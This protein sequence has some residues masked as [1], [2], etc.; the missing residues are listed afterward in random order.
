[1]SS[2]EGGRIGVV[3]AGTMGAG[4][5][6]SCITAGFQV[7][8]YDSFPAALERCRALI[9]GN[10]EKAAARGRF[11]GNIEATIGRLT[12]A[13]GPE[14]LA[15]CELVIEAAPE[16][17]ELKR[18][19]F[20]ELDRVCRADATLATNTSSIPVTAI[21]AGTAHPERVVGM[22][23][24][25]PVPRMRLVEVI[26]AARTAEHSVEH[27]RAVGEALGKRVILAPDTPGF[28]VNRCGRPYYGEALRLLQER[29]ADVAQIDRIC[30]M[31][32]GFRMGP[33]ELIDLVGV[34]VNFAIAQSFAELSFGEPRW[35]P[36]PLQAQLVASGDHGRKTGRGW[37]TYTAD[38]HRPEDPVPPE[39]SVDPSVVV[40]ILGNGPT[41]ARLRELAG[42][43]GLRTR[44]EVDASVS[45]TVFADPDVSAAQIGSVPRPIVSCAAHS[46]AFRG[47]HG[48]VG[49]C[50][51]NLGRAVPVVE[52][53]RLGSTSDG[54]AAQ[55]AALFTGLGI[56]VEWVAD[57]PGLVVERVL[58]QIV[59]EAAFAVGEGVATE[60]DVDTGVTLG[61]NY[62]LGPLA[63]G[64]ELGWRQVAV[65]LDGVW[66]ERREE[67]YRPAPALIRAAAGEPLSR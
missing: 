62:P 67:R 18:Q 53:T 2:S 13:A 31:A 46:L 28:I 11:D 16:S 15:G 45:A 10:L 33:F 37:Y 32:G 14:A 57:A 5:A 58:A 39:S 48:A 27:A 43:A 3:G 21:A 44:D 12:T 63:W 61:L 4:I 41:A 36:S 9:H 40:A 17:L 60:A 50:L 54:D 25:N 7:V 23:F 49:F 51:P 47:I 52:L 29:V 8:V 64:A 22:H 6:E 66:H 35:R 34:D 20:A 19:I 1:M 56:H 55:A 24:F 38:G 59:N 42:S 30:R 65:T 26:S